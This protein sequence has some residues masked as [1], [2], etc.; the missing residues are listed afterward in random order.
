MIVKRLISKLK[1]GEKEMKYYGLIPSDTPKLM[2]TFLS[3]RTYANLPSF[4]QE[5]GF[6]D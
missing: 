6:V 5:K 3:P 4:V 2:W 1:P